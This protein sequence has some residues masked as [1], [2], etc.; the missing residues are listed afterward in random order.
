MEFKLCFIGELLTIITWSLVATSL[1][2]CYSCYID[3][4][5]YGFPHILLS[6]QSDSNRLRNWEFLRKDLKIWIRPN[7]KTG[8]FNIQSDSKCPKMTIKDQFV[9]ISFF[10]EKLKGFSLWIIH[11]RN[12]KISEN[13][14]SNKILKTNLLG[15]Y[16]YIW[17][18]IIAYSI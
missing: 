3:I 9:Q 8:N 14:H 5:Y 1:F 2:I 13:I 17:V 4:F 12:F 11:R 10:P 18:K 15:H 6:V 16:A 7:S